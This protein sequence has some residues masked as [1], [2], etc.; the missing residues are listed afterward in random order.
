MDTCWTP[1]RAKRV[2]TGA[3]FPVPVSCSGLD[4]SEAKS[5]RQIVST[6]MGRAGVERDRVFRHRRSCRTSRWPPRSTHGRG[7]RIACQRPELWR[8]RLANPCAAAEQKAKDQ[9]NDRN[10]QENLGEVRRKTRNASEPQKSGNDG[11][12]GKD[13][14]PAEHGTIPS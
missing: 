10:D 1:P 4:A 2:R 3:A 14:S 5:R 11:N 13:D 7:G 8:S 12:N 9:D 6:P